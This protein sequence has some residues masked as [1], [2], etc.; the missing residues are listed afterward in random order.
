MRSSRS[1]VRRW[2]ASGRTPE[3]TLRL[4]YGLVLEARDALGQWGK[5]L[6]KW[7][8]RIPY[9]VAVAFGKPLPPAVTA[10]EV[11]LVIQEL[12]ADTTIRDAHTILV[13]EHGQIVEQGSHDELLER[14]GAYSRLYNAQFAGAAV[15]VT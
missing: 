12:S 3:P 7:P 10:A 6:T 15:E 9:R 1:L 8:E 13:M 11:R 5:G 2:S 4:F 14:D